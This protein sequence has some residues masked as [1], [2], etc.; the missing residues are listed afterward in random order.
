MAIVQ[1]IVNIYLCFAN[2]LGT[3]YTLLECYYSGS[4]YSNA[5]LSSGK[6]SKDI[7]KIKRFRESGII[8]VKQRLF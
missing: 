2:S 1:C 8:A 7:Y 6:L 4:G 5:T 3:F